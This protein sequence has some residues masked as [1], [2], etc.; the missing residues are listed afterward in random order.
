[1]C[2][3]FAIFSNIRAIMDYYHFLLSMDMAYDPELMYEYLKNKKNNSLY[4]KYNFPQ[5]PFVPSMSMPIIYSEKGKIRMDWMKWGII[6][7][8]S[9]DE[10]FALKLINARAET[11]EEKNSFKNSLKHKRCL[12]PVNAFYEWDKS[13]NRHQIKVEN[14]ELFSFA[15]IW[16]TWKTPKGDELNTFTIITCEPNQFISE[17]HNR[18]PVILSPEQYKEWLLKGDKR[19]LLPY[20]GELTA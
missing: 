20:S 10:S 5:D 12:I 1:M 13:K 4:G 7:S 9:K 17:I 15:G 3:Q 19:L 2:G 6:P 18:M 14:S 8:W 11:L 16:D